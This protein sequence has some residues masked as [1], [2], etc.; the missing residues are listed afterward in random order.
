MQ[1][2]DFRAIVNQIISD[3]LSSTLRLDTLTW[4][5]C[6]ENEIPAVLSVYG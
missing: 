1:L 6:K 2:H 3:V 5:V 4:D